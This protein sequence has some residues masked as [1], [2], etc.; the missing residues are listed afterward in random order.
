MQ[1]AAHPDRETEKT[2]NECGKAIC[3]ECARTVSENVYCESCLE[4]AKQNLTGALQEMTRNINWGKALIAGLVVTAVGALVWD[5][6]EVWFN[7]RLGIIA[8]AIGYGVAIAVMWG[9]GGKRGLGLQI[10][11]VVLTL[12]GIAGGLY[13]SLHDQLLMEVAKGTIQKPELNEWVF[14]AVLFPFSLLQV[15]I[16]SWVIIAFGLYQSFVMPAMPKVALEQAAP[17]ATTGPSAGGASSG[18]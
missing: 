6:I 11:S 3:E 1:C 8:I 5:K 18:S 17:A 2:C 14:C 7:I 15:G 10:L 4:K 12:I 9:A 13:L 16:I